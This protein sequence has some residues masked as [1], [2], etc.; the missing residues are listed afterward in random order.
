[1]TPSP[2]DT[3]GR[4]EGT[5][6][7]DQEAGQQARFSLAG[8]G[9]A[10]D[11]HPR[12][13]P[14]AG[15]GGGEESAMS[16]RHQ[17]SVRRQFDRQ[18]G[19]YLAGG[20]MG[21]RAVLDAILAA[22]PA[23]A[24]RQVLD[25]ACGAGLLL[26]AYR[27]AG[28]EVA[29]VDLSPAML[30]AAAAA[31]GP[32]AGLVVADAARLPI[33][34]AAFDLVTCK[35]AFHYFPDPARVAAELA[36]VCRPGGRVAVIDRVASD[37]PGRCAAHNRLERLRTP[38]KVRVYPAG[39]LAAL[40]EAAGLAVVRRVVLTQAMGFDEWADAAGA[41]DRAL[42]LRSL[43]VGPGGEDLTGLEPRE[44]SGRLVVRHRTLLLVAQPVRN[45]PSP[46]R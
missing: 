9:A 46:P 23:G 33:G 35:L 12:D 30:G 18:A 1:M 43:L 40:L 6:G 8:P 5:P 19:H 2:H 7:K 24:G 16:A 37:D 34:P 31:L 25:V 45:L 14:F 11:N 10:G 36:R 21:D 3:P 39:E 38:N 13:V 27:D 15:P 29:G 32:A 17:D 20:A 28:A 26:R 44:E 41:T 22:A 4:D 42:E